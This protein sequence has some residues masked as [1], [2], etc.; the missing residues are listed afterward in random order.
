MKPEELARKID[1]SLLKPEATAV[2]VEKCCQDA[3][4]YGFVTVFIQPC[5][6]ELSE[7]ALRGSSV[8]V[9]TVVSFPHGTQTIAAKCYQAEDALNKGAREIDMVMNIGMLKSGDFDSVVEDIGGVIRIAR[10]KEMAEK[11][12]VKVIIETGLLTDDEKRIAS[13]LVEVAGADFV[14]TST[15]FGFGG[16]TVDDVK[17]LRASVGPKLGVKASGGIRTLEQALALIEAGAS[18]VGTS[19]GPEIIE[20][21]KKSAV[22]S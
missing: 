8:K 7:K 18:R 17:L 9:G 1:Y 20:E 15:G 12:I 6:V 4:K 19:T 2:E 5:W 14:K 21:L 10:Y 16:A 13:Q 11:I 3:I 22:S